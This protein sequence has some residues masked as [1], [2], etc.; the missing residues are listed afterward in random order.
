MSPAERFWSR[1]DQSGGADACWP[2]TGRTNP[3]GYG[4]VSFAGR[5]R[6][7]HRVAWELSNGKR[8]PS[9]LLVCH[10]CDVRRC[11]NPRHLWL[12]THA[13][14]VAYMHTK[15]RGVNPPRKTDEANG[16]AKLS[17]LAVQTIR[18]MAALG[19]SARDL[20]ETFGVGRRHVRRI[21][22]GERRAKTLATVCAR[23]LK[24]LTRRERRDGVCPR[25][26]R[27][28]REAA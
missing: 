28:A 19:W 18:T 15:R 27:A 6:R 24:R 7:A 16:N 13:E 22:R 12:R 3:K 10:S 5:T 23:C 25:C 2:W 11:C 20:A 26:V 14:N 8:A 1:V 4:E 17:D 21:V 9:E